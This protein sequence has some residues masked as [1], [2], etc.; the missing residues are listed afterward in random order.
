MTSYG[1][2]LMIGLFVGPMILL[3]IFAWSSITMPVSSEGEPTIAAAIVDDDVAESAAGVIVSS[4]AVA[5]DVVADEAPDTRLRALPRADGVPDRSTSVVEPVGIRINDIGV[6]GDVV[7]V[8]VESDGAFEVPSARQVGWY[9][10]GSSAGEPGSTV[11]AAHIAYE[12]VDGVFRGLASISPGADV[13]VVMD[14]G[15]VVNYRVVEIAE[16]DKEELP[17]EELFSE[18]GNDRL[19]LIT[20]GGTFNPGVRSYDSNVVAYAEPVTG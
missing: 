13:E 8:G 17:V 6:D 4:A 15:T 1:R 12:G 19:A 7:P 9:R 20:C 18:S 2:Q 3:G 16:Y 11:L 14:D 5:A 10:F